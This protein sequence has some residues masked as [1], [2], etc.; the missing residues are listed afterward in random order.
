M[1]AILKKEI[2][3]FFATPVG[4]LVIG[5]FLITNGLFLWVIEGEYNIFNYGF[6]DLSGYY[7]LAPW[8]FL[9]L[10]PAITM[11]SFSE[12]KK[13]GTL[14]LLLTK[15]ISL[16]QLIL[17]KYLGVLSL[18]IIALIP[19]ILYIYTVHQLGNPVGNIDIGSAIGS[20]IGL[21]GV[22]MIY[23]SIGIFT[24][25][26]SNNQIVSFILAVILCFIMYFGFDALSESTMNTVSL[27][28]IK[29][30][31]ENISKGIIDTR[32]IVYFISTSALFLYI[33]KL[34]L[35]KK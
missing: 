21:L 33:T 2:Q 1:L 15:P 27:I 18:I 32:N 19:T 28:G 25:T 30:H 31:F 17:G 14:E 10:I 23:S 8:L 35:A 20:Y 4:Y 7:F 11:K 26:L 13:Q 5:V 29:S 9:F 16:T 12:E 34:I 24:S 3:S 6:A 22:A